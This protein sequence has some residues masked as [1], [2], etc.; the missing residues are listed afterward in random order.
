METLLRAL[1]STPPVK[2]LMKKPLL[3][4][5]GLLFACGL[6][7]MSIHTS[8]AGY[9][10]PEYET[11]KSDQGFEIRKYPAMVSAATAMTSGSGSNPQ[12]FLKR[13]APVPSVLLP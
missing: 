5:T 11:L 4:T 10:S 3:L 2:T 12:C 7:W 13:Y 9:E 8:R 6:I 1:V